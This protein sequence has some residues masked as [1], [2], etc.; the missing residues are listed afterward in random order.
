[1]ELELCTVIYFA[2]IGLPVLGPSVTAIPVPEVLPG[3]GLV[4]ISG[5]S[6]KTLAGSDG[7]ASLSAFPV[8]KCLMLNS[9]WSCHSSSVG[10]FDSLG[11]SSENSESLNWSAEIMV[12]R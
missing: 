1:M 4:T 6:D 9:P 3:K 2:P 8:S 10:S 12:P 11:P 7:M 5:V